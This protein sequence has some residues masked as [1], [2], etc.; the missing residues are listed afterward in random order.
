METPGKL[1]VAPF[2]DRNRPTSHQQQL[3]GQSLPDLLWWPP[4]TQDTPSLCTVRAGTTRRFCANLTTKLGS[5][6]KTRLGGFPVLQ[7]ERK[8]KMRAYL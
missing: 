3:Y 8:E 7:L 4:I 5:P 2:S 6:L 1:P